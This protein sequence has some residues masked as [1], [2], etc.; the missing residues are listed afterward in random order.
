M[1]TIDHGTL[2]AVAHHG[3]CCKPCRGEGNRYGN[4]RRRLIAYGQWQPFVD[5]GPVRDHVRKLQAAGLGAQRIALIADVSVGAMW[6]LL[7]GDLHRGTPPS[8]RIRPATAAAILAVRV[9]IDTLEPRVRIDAVGTRRRIQALAA[10]GWSLAYQ[11]ERLGRA[12]SNYRAILAKRSVAVATAR[13]VR[14]LYDELSMTPAPASY[15]ASVARGRARRR[16]WLPPLA[17][18][19]DLL[20][21]PDAELETEIARRVADMSDDDLRRS[22]SSYK[23]DRERSPLVVAAALEWRRRLKASKQDAA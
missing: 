19:D 23:H 6:R 21:V 22:A 1:T 5:A 2:T 10:I 4:H 16:G 8:K 12:P 13:A 9:D 14:D 15:G 7:Y 17:W 3:C 20:D 11:A 18:D